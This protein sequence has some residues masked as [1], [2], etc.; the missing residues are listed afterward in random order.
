MQIDVYLR[1]Y[2]KIGIPV[3]VL[4]EKAVV[5]E[6]FKVV[7]IEYLLVLK[8]ITLEQRG[9]SPKGRKDFIDSVSLFKFGAL[10]LKKVIRIIKKYELE[11][12]LKSWKEFLGENF[13]IEELKINKHEYARLKKELL[14]NFF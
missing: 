7:E 12:V 3:E 1:H 8:L 4:L 9:R 5:L 14:S 13:E 2:S 11:D 10:D 6:G